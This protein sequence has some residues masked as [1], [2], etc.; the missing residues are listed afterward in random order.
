MMYKKPL[1]RVYILCETPLEAEVSRKLF[2]YFRPYK[3]AIHLNID[4][5]HSASK[6]I[7][8]P[9]SSRNPSFDTELSYF[10]KTQNH[11]YKILILLIHL[12]IRHLNETGYHA[13][14]DDLTIVVPSTPNDDLSYTFG[15]RLLY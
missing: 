1:L 4:S 13:T 3:L 5:I 14:G 7:C 6:I 11:L 10:I 8:I 9:R 12:A 2:E 15:W